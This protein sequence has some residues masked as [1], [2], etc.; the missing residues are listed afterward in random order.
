VAPLAAN[1]SCNPGPINMF[2]SK[3]KTHHQVSIIDKIHDSLKRV[4]LY[5]FFATSFIYA[6][7]SLVIVKHLLHSNTENKLH[8][9]KQELIPGLRL[10]DSVFVYKTLT[11]GINEHPLVRV[12]LIYPNNRVISVDTIKEKN[13]FSS[14]Y[15][16][17]NLRKIFSLR[18][19]TKFKIFQDK[20]IYHLTVESSWLYYLKKVGFFYLGVL[21]FFTFFWIIAFFYINKISQKIVFDLVSL[22]KE[23]TSSGI[24]NFS[25]NKLTTVHTME[26]N[27][28]AKSIHFAMVNYRKVITAEEKSRADAELGKKITQIAHDI[29]SPLMA[30]E[31]VREKTLDDYQ[32]KKI[33]EL[34]TERLQEI[35]DG[36]LNKNKIDL[37]SQET[38]SVVKALII[39]VINEKKEFS[40]R[41]LFSVHLD[42]KINDVN[43]NICLIEFKRVM[44]NLL[45]NAIEANYFQDKVDIYLKK[46]DN[47]CLIKITD[48]GRGFSEIVLSKFAERGVSTKAY[49]N[50]LGLWHAF[51]FTKRL[52]GILD[53]ENSSQGSSVIVKLPLNT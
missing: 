37:I 47:Y 45:Q 49:G 24:V 21:V 1:H 41:T 35:A 8:R 43:I 3:I 9:I 2:F 48:Y 20:Y 46:N 31:V 7:F 39:Q 19:G 27:S 42:D 51:E 50:G 25:F 28:I 23:I 14:I 53:I 22:E 4:I 34:A 10:D 5:L 40:P 18:L 30:L 32:N 38:I 12:S 44:S 16:F 33:I 6:I 15:F 11:S 36:I 13:I 26:I 52:N 17:K 29:K